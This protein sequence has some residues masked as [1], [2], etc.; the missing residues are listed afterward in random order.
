MLPAS[1]GTSSAVRRHSCSQVARWVSRSSSK[2]GAAPARSTAARSG[3]L[4]AGSREVCRA[5]VL[6]TVAVR[7]GGR[8]NRSRWTARW[9]SLAWVT[10]TPAVSRAASPQPM[11]ETR[12]RQRSQTRAGAL[13]PASM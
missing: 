13:V 3:S 11:S 6:S 5:T 9:A 7:P 8:D 10:G 4:M 1:P 2:P 12:V